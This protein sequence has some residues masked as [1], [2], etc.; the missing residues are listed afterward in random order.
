MAPG[1]NTFNAI[2]AAHRLRGLPQRSCRGGQTPTLCSEQAQLQGQEGS[3]WL[4]APYEAPRVR[5]VLC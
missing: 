3:W 5:F 4:R 1:L 2:P